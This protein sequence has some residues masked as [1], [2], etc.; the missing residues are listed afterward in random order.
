MNCN[1]FSKTQ[2]VA[3][4]VIILVMKK[5][6]A[7]GIDTSTAICATWSEQRIMLL[8][9]DQT[10][11]TFQQAEQ[12][13]GGSGPPPLIHCL[14]RCR[15]TEKKGRLNRASEGICCFVFSGKR[16]SRSSRSSLHWQ[17]D[18]LVTGKCGNGLL[19][20]NKYFLFCRLPRKS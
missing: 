18:K 15:L 2:C 19:V 9:Q 17:A 13:N 12:M 11:L 6:S 4:A 5:I 16:A 10:D 20:L 3:W 1:I 8:L 7:L 14:K